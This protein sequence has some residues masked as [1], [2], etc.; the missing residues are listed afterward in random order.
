MLV[1]PLIAI[2]WVGANPA[3][4]T[5]QDRHGASQGSY[6]VTDPA[7]GWCRAAAALIRAGRSNPRHPCGVSRTQ[8]PT[9][10]VPPPHT[11]S[12]CLSYPPSTVG[13]ME[14]S[15]V[16]AVEVLLLPG[17]DPLAVAAA[18][19][20]VIAWAHACQLEALQ[21]VACEQPEIVDP[22]GAL[23]DPAPAEVATS[24][25][26]STGA[27]VRGTTSRSASA[28]STAGSPTRS[29]SATK[30]AWITSRARRRACRSRDS[31]RRRRR[32]GRGDRQPRRPRHGG[33]SLSAGRRRG[34]IA[35][36]ARDRFS[37]EIRQ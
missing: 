12:S 27:A 34:I 28:A 9:L 30:S 33:C 8:S 18:S 15:V 4:G 1:L 13:G 14:E 36:F 21:Q 11:F 37:K 25:R 2:R 32:S 19:E 17:V 10:T 22:C 29:A 35:L 3:R 20:A 23:V 24:L 31:R 26:W 6:E 5:G 16:A 7:P